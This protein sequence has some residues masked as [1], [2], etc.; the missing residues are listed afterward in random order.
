MRTLIATV[1]ASAT[2][3]VPAFAATEP[4]GRGRVT[5]SFVAA[6]SFTDAAL[7]DSQRESSRTTVLDALRD[8]LVAA[9]EASL[10][11]GQRLSI[12]V[13]DIDLVGR[14]RPVPSLQ[15]ERIRL[16]D[17]VSWPRVTLS[18]AVTG[19]DGGAVAAANDVVVENRSYLVAP[20]P[21][22]TDD[23][24]RHEKAMLR[25]WVQATFAAR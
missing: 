3:A 12:T 4:D 18:Y 19:E 13:T 7:D 8:T 16:L 15:N 23:P 11:A 25:R 2:L 20:S 17:E 24:L 22:L 1:L 10:P 21:G 6:E 14:I 5:V 9:A